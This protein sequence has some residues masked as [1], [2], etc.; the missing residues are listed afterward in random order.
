MNNQSAILRITV[1]E[2]DTHIIYIDQGTKMFE[3]NSN[4]GAKYV[5]DKNYNKE[6]ANTWFSYVLWCMH[7]ISYVDRIPTK[8]ILICGENSIWYS[9]LLSRYSYAQF[10]TDKKKISVIIETNI[11]SYERH[12]ETISKFAI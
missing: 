2:K 6:S 10:F 4:I 8:I 5:K 7:S 12:K 11:Q 1:N 3:Y 9:E